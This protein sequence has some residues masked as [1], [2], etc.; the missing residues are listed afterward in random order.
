MRSATV[1]MQYCRIA[2]EAP[3]SG[4]N[5]YI[6][7]S[8]MSSSGSRAFAATERMDRWTAGSVDR[9]RPRVAPGRSELHGLHARR[10]LDGAGYRMQRERGSGVNGLL[11]GSFGGS[12]A[13]GVPDS[14]CPGF[15][16]TLTTRATESAGTEGE[17]YPTRSRSARNPKRRP[18]PDE[19]G[20]VLYQCI[21]NRAGVS[22]LRRAAPEPRAVR[23]VQVDSRG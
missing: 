19:A 14:C 6:S 18:A 3:R 1:E 10:V 7:T 22:H 15:M 23:V 4:R 11:V 17:R 16:D 20:A 8:A 9:L 13:T 12:T 5:R 21:M 2:A